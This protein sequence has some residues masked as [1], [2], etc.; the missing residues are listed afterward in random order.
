MLA[1][2][3]APPVL[4]ANEQVGPKFP[5]SA[6]YTKHAEKCFAARGGRGDEKLALLSQLLPAEKAVAQNP[7][8]CSNKNSWE[9]FWSNS[10]APA[11]KI[12]DFGP[13]IDELVQNGQHWP[14][15]DQN[16]SMFGRNSST[17]AAGAW[18]LLQKCPWEF[19]FEHFFGFCATARPT[20]NNL[21][22][23]CT[24]FRGL[25]CRVYLLVCG[26]MSL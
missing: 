3:T 22:I 1:G 16:R 25:G 6:K 20:G 15:L 13:T 17:F 8:Q 4:A 7:K 26:D 24:L 14:D 23:S 5:P 12:D 18:E 19:L 2:P 9:H 10:R 11:A 21:F